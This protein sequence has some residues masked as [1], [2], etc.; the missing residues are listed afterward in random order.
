M[1]EEQHTEVE[2][3][4]GAETSGEDNELIRS[5][6]A[7]IKEK[8]KA[9]KA[10]P[11]VTEVEQRGYEKAKRD[12]SIES[13][14]VALGQPKAVRKLIEEKL[15]DAEAISREVVAEA[16]KAEGF[17]IAEEP[18]GGEESQQG[19]QTAED[20][21]QVANLGNQ[22]A[23]A[24]NQQTGNKLDEKIANAETP[25]ELAQ[26]MREAGQAQ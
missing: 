8:D 14:L 20:L 6:R 19:Q 10:V 2:T 11:N 7:Q 16:L 13:Q 23:N 3:T 5:L 17:D 21:A 4:E 22:V 12:I 15:E 24:A 18:E 9:L 25:A 26:I 1:T